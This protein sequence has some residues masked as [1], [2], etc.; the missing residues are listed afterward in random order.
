VDNRW[1]P[2]VAK[3]SDGKKYVFAVLSHYIHHA[4]VGNF[5]NTTLGIGDKSFTTFGRIGH[6]IFKLDYETLDYVDMRETSSDLDIVDPPLC[7]DER[8][9]VDF[10]S[11]KSVSETYV[12]DIIG[13]TQLNGIIA[14]T[15]HEAGEAGCEGGTLLLVGVSGYP[16]YSGFSDEPQSRVYGSTTGRHVGKGMAY[17]SNDLKPV[18]KNP[19]INGYADTPDKFG[20]KG[21]YNTTCLGEGR[22][23]MLRVG[24]NI[25]ASKFREGETYTVVVSELDCSPPVPNKRVVPLSHNLFTKYCF[26]VSSVHVLDSLLSATSTSDIRVKVG[27]GLEDVKLTYEGTED[28]SICFG[29]RD[30]TFNDIHPGSEL[31]FNET[32]KLSDHEEIEKVDSISIGSLSKVVQTMYYVNTSTIDKNCLK[33][34]QTLASEEFVMD[35]TEEGNVDISPLYSVCNK[36][37]YVNYENCN[38]DEVN[39]NPG[40]LLK[41]KRGDT[42]DNDS[43]RV[44]V[45]NLGGSWW[46]R[47]ATGIGEDR[48]NFYTPQGNGHMESVDRYYALREVYM[49]RDEV[50]KEEQRL[51]GVEGLLSNETDTIG[52]ATLRIDELN[53][54]LTGEILEMRVEALNKLSDLDKTFLE[55]SVGKFKWSNG[56]KVWFSPGASP[57]VWNLDLAVIELGYTH[58]IPNGTLRNDEMGYWSHLDIEANNVMPVRED[59]IV[60]TTKGGLVASLDAKSGDRLFSQRTSAT[61]PQA[62]GINPGNF[63]GICYP[64]GDIA[65]YRSRT[66]YSPFPNPVTG[67][68]VASDLGT[69]VGFNF[70]TGNIDWFTIFGKSDAAHGVTCGNGFAFVQDGYPVGRL[71]VV[72]AENGNKTQYV[73]FEECTGTNYNCVEALVDGGDVYVTTPERVVHGKFEIG[74]RSSLSDEVGRNLTVPVEE[75][76][77]PKCQKFPTFLDLQTKLD[78]DNIILYGYN[79]KTAISVHHWFFEG[80]AQN[81]GSPHPAVDRTQYSQP[82]LSWL[83]TPGG[84]HGTHA[85]LKESRW[86]S[87]ID[88]IVGVTG[89]NITCSDLTLQA[90]KNPAEDGLLR[91][92]YQGPTINA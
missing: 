26:S 78:P 7:E 5:V 56:S 33:Y 24:D 35:V 51:S 54:M 30:A 76:I 67:E 91:D 47:G 37:T 16:Y 41:K 28:S 70:K 74:S 17:C 81:G 83:D 57:D 45:Q 63:G 84:S 73:D 80:G 29:L 13:T 15:S 4:D 20:N 48:E 6:W 44:S 23:R 22:K 62:S 8:E 55:S 11:P 27:Q 77:L 43:E 32:T 50:I 65:V 85:S 61:V 39:L 64:G 31:Y 90:L 25:P 12:N 36:T 14:Y 3:A 82:F 71:F 19:A 60:F 21:P 53:E 69:L 79:A 46:F 52:N 88:Y 87:V 66:Q 2:I 75:R 89:P 42:L 34:S 40:I 1:A 10:S 58:N 49:K 72:D 59:I 9:R 68:I 92:P 18:W 38:K 86:V